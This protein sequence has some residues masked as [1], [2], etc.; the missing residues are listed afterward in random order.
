M[1]FERVLVG[2]L[3]V[4][5]M[6]TG[7]SLAVPLAVFLILGAVVIIRRPHKDNYHTYRF[8]ANMA[9]S[10]VIMILF[11]VYSL[12]LH[13]EKDIKPILFYLPMIICGLVMLSVLINLATLIYSVYKNYKS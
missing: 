1:L 8:V 4:F 6:S 12:A 7:F 2:S 9:I 11:I 5:M 10:A 13:K 3:M